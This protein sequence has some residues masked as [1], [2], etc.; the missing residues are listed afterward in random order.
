MDR[1]YF[2]EEAA[3]RHSP[4]VPPV[5]KALLIANLAI[6]FVDMLFLGD[7]IR[8]W[9]AFTT[10][11]CFGE[12]KLWELITF[13]FLHGSV[14]HVLFNSIGLW[15]FGPFME[16]WWGS[17][18][19]LAFY[20]LCG[21]AGALFFSLLVSVDLLPHR[22]LVGA[23]AG[24]YGLLVGVARVMPHQVV[25]LLFPPISLTLRQLALVVIGIAVFAILGDLFLDLDFF[26]FQNSGG[27]AGHLGGAMLGFLLV[28]R[29]GLLGKGR[30]RESKIVRPKE[31]QREPKLKPRSRR[32][33]EEANE[34]DRILDKIAEEGMQSLTERERDILQRAAR[35]RDES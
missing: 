15:I 24:V 5:T 17:R 4:G 7:A 33:A 1:D 20:L 11:S 30:K 32:P 10:A 34:I 23:S 12:G 25:H 14:G 18:R 9:G 35:A 29:P 21:V 16:K 13:Q 19:Y 6:Y 27:E 28:S 2:R 3:R 26:L 22:G 8:E 31:F